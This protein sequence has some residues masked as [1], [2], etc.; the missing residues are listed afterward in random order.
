MRRLFVRVMLSV[1]LAGVTASA[2]A[3]MDMPKPAPE[4]KKLD[5]F[6]GNWKVE[7][8]M[9]P[10][11]MGPGGKVSGTDSW[12]WM[13]GNFFLVNHSKFAGAGMGSGS[14][15]AFMG[16]D[17]D[18]KMYTYDEFNSMGETVH[19][20]GTVDGNTWTWV[21]D[22]KMGSQM[23]KG[24]FTVMVVSPTSYTFKFEVSQDGTTWNTVMEGKEMKVT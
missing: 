4:L 18:K 16:Y 20:T 11:P 24:R 6:A 12:G 7:G 23:M 13:E 17:A 10:G 22:A 14:G 15:T 5:Y 3:Q 9:K 8:E 21:N 2:Q 1:V 19:S